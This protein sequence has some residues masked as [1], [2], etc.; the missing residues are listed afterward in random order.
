VLS[1]S[2]W[3]Y[4]AAMLAWSLWLSFRLLRWLP[5]A[6]RAYT[7]GGLWRSRVGTPA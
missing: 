6:W 5:W 3:F 7:H 1:V 2:I 4:K